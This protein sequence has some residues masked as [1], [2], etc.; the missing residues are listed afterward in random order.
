MIEVFSKCYHAMFF[1]DFILPLLLECPEK[2]AA[3]VRL[4]TDCLQSV[5]SQL[6][7]RAFA[8]LPSIEVSLNTVQAISSLSVNFLHL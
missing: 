2:L 5:N 6:S 4:M 1:G 7:G 3:F 8:Q